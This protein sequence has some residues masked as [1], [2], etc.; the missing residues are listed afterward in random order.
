VRVHHR[1]ALA[2]HLQLNQERLTLVDP[3]RTTPELARSACDLVLQL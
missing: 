1:T 2:A 3:Q